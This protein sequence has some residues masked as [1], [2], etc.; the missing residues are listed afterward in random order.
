MLLAR[1]F[2]G[3]FGCFVDVGQCALGDFLGFSNVG[4]GNLVNRT[5]DRG[6]VNVKVSLGWY[7]G[8]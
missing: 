2:F 3:P 4:R 7:D 8:Y 1:V 5:I 6:G